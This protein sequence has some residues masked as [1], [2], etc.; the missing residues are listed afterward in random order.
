MSWPPPH[1]D[2]TELGMKFSMSSRGVFAPTSWQERSFQREPC[3]EVGLLLCQ[4]SFTICRN[5]GKGLGLVFFFFFCF[6][7][8]GLCHP[9]C[10]SSSP[11]ARGRDMHAF[12]RAPS[13]TPSVR[14]IAR[15]QLAV[16]QRKAMTHGAAALPKAKYFTH[17]AGTLARVMK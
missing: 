7:L 2:N 1:R 6:H 12:P 13:S 17:F 3:P 5:E 11:D 15:S 4:G 14:R 9:P 16:S 8:L 10:P